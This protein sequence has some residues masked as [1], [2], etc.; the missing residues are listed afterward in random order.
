MREEKEQQHRSNRRFYICAN[1]FPKI[2]SF[3]FRSVFVSLI[4]IRIKWQSK[5]ESYRDNEK[6]GKELTADQKIAVSKYDE[7]AMTLEFAREFSK[8]IVQIV[9]AAEKDQ[10]KK[11]KKDESSKKQS[12][13][14][15]IREVL[16]LQDILHQLRDD[17][18][19]QDFLEGN[20]GAF[21]VDEQQ[22]ALL[23]IL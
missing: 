18:V 5:L 2:H 14:S 9:S 22:L 7:V 10:K 12:E 20:N 6:N 13:L 23:D 3:H 8:Q 21:K 4:F 1:D 17:D 19:R 15:K 16:M 11:Q